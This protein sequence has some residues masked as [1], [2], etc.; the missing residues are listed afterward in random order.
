ML[1]KFNIVDDLLVSKVVQTQALRQVFVYRQVSTVL[2][3][4]RCVWVRLTLSR[5]NYVDFE[6]TV[7][8]YT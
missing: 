4:Y 6:G 2:G 7:A 5:I 1:I 3:N 8:F